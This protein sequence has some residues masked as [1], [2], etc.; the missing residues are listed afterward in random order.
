[1]ARSYRGSFERRIGLGGPYLG[2]A[3]AEPAVVAIEKTSQ[4]APRQCAVYFYH[5][6]PRGE[7][8]RSSAEGRSHWLPGQAVRRAR[9]DQLR[10][11]R[12]ELT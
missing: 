1:M 11:N 2:L 7:R 5:G 10:P 3:T 9:L 6:L 12:P 8:P 4:A